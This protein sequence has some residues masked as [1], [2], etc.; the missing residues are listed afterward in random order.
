MLS[1]CKLAADD[2]CIYRRAKR[3][4]GAQQTLCGAGLVPK[5]L[6]KP[7]ALRA[8]GTLPRRQAQRPLRR[9]RTHWHHAHRQWCTHRRTHR[10]RLPWPPSR[11]GL[12]VTHKRPAV[13]P[14]RRQPGPPVDASAQPQEK[15][16]GAAARARAGH[17]ACAPWSTPSR[18]LW[19]AKCVLP[20]ATRSRPEKTWPRPNAAR[21]RAGTA[22]TARCSTPPR[23]PAARHAKRC[24]R[25]RVLRIFYQTM[26]VELHSRKGSLG[27]EQECGWYKQLRD[28]HPPRHLEVP[29]VVLL[30][31]A[32]PRR[33]SRLT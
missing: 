6:M 28:D 11:P 33:I 17:V 31:A 3:R 16:P 25:N 13:L 20:C 23:P 5:R 1:L 9:R 15:V 26:V 29:P 30:I 22:R 24:R 8:Q 19:P 7:A 10:R 2:V 18:W 4:P 14:P 21:A 32:T 12:L 27:Y